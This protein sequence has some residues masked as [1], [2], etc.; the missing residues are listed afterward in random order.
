MSGV[1]IATD[2][3]RTMIYSKGALG[4][5][6][7][8]PSPPLECVEVHD[9]RQ[10]AFMTRAAATSL[11]AVSEHASVVAVTTRVRDQLSRVTLPGPRPEYAVAANGGL[12]LVRGKVD[13]SWS[14]RVASSLSAAAPLSVI[15]RHVAKVCRP[16]WTLKIRNAEDLFCYAVV[17]RSALP[18]E[19]YAESSAWARER[20]WRLS[21]Q[22]RKLY[23]VPDALTKAAAVAEV[24]RRLDADLVLSAGDSLLDMDLLEVA[25]RA[26]LAR[27]GELFERGWSAA[28]VSTTVNAGV[29]AGEEI[30]G[31][32]AEQVRGSRS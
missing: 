22:G 28:H 10:A 27:H 29:L 26:I 30:V 16:E 32:F 3:D 14:A 2:L 11:I 9:G 12:L 7:R 21:L 25:D 6:A 19:F 8:A 1:L 23:W 5:P 13:T 20:G 15:W 24:R 4:L 31:W 17:H 18:P